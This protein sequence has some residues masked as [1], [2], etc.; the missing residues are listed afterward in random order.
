MF[1][2]LAV[3]DR[4]HVAGVRNSGNRI[5]QRGVDPAEDRYVRRDAEGKRAYGKQRESRIF[6]KLP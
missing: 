4:N 3:H 6:A 2:A 1:A 5:E